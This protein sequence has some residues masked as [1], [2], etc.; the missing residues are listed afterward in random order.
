MSRQADCREADVLNRTRR[1]NH[2]LDERQPA[3]R[4]SDGQRA[5]GCKRREEQH[6]NQQTDK[7]RSLLDIRVGENLE[8]TKLARTPP[9]MTSTKDG[10]ARARYK[11]GDCRTAPTALRRRSKMAVLLDSQGEG[12]ESVE[13]FFQTLVHYSL[14]IEKT[15][16]WCAAA[17]VFPRG[18][19]G[20]VANARPR[21]TQVARG[22]PDS[23]P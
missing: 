23:R 19:R 18:L 3:R 1:A 13:A 16:R 14:A 6:P 4:Q 8:R 22:H 17:C 5:C 15:N 20:S 2:L 12:R 9:M 10:L 21:A 7:V 11:K